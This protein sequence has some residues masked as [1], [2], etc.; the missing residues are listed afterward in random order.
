MHEQRP[1]LSIITVVLNDRPGFLRTANS[2]E[3]QSGTDF[4]WI[5]VDGKS[6]DGTLD[7]IASRQHLIAAKVSERDAGI[8]DA[9]N[10]GIA[11]ANGRYILF[12]NAGDTFASDHVVASF[13]AELAGHEKDPAIVFGQAIYEYPNGYSLV[14]KP[15][16][17]E[18]QIWHRT[19]ASHQSM[20]LRTDLQ[21]QFP[22]SLSLKVCADYDVVCRIFKAEPQCAYL[23]EV[24]AVA[25]HGGDS[26][27]H[28]N[29]GIRLREAWQVQRDVLELGL[30][31]RLAS[32]AKRCISIVAEGLLSSNRGAQM[33]GGLVRL[34]R[35]E[36]AGSRN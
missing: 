15:G 20:F 14:Q 24:V 28:N 7:V 36:P 6:T 1:S 8:F 21:K 16:R 4:E 27:S 30:P 3:A 11:R 10:K 33:T 26:F 19:P 25:A 22:Y 29:P 31:K 34:F 32:A 9:M 23:D 5:V 18:E 12:L 2:I 17:I 13:T 35:S